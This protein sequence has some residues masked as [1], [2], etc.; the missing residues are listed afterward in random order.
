MWFFRVLTRP[1]C[2]HSPPSGPVHTWHPPPLRSSTRLP[3]ASS[4]TCPKTTVARLR[5]RRRSPS[6]PTTSPRP[7]CTA[8]TLNNKTIKNRSRADLPLVLSLSRIL[9]LFLLPLRTSTVWSAP[10]FRSVPKL[11]RIDVKIGF[12]LN[13]IQPELFWHWRRFRVCC[14]R[15]HFVDSTR[16]YRN[17]WYYFCLIETVRRRTMIIP[18]VTIFFITLGTLFPEG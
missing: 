12:E 14:I 3:I 18:I 10:L 15:G 6:S 16:T 17:S 11:A 9:F 8:D 5:H 7:D 4:P 1:S 13:Q 2:H